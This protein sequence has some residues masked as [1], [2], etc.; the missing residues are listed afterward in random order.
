MRKFLCT[1]TLPAGSITPEQA[2]QIAEAAQHDP[3]VRGYRSFIN[4]SEGKVVCV[5]EAHDREA[6][7]SWFHK[8]DIPYDTIVPVEFE[9]ER[10][11][12][13]DL[14]HEAVPVGAAL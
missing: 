14:R 9:G 6:V 12:I 4:L 10:G 3:N 13:H 5:I 11:M 2:C 7:A 8:M 1:H